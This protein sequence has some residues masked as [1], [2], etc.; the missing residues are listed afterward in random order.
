MKRG[1]NTDLRTSFQRIRGGF[2]NLPVLCDREQDVCLEAS[3]SLEGPGQRAVVEGTWGLRSWSHQG[4][5]V[6][7]VA[8]CGLARVSQSILTMGQKDG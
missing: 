2:P 7:V 8:C 4:T 6:P 1:L 5:G 3:G